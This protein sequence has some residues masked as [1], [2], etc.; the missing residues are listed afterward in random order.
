MR[1]RT[2]ALLA[3]WLPWSAF[4]GV[5]ASSEGTNSE[6]ERLAARNAVDGL[7]STAWAEG[8]DGNGAGAWLEVRLDGPTDVS[9]VSLWPGK[10]DRGNRGLREYGRP[11]TVTVTLAGAGD[12]VSQTVRVLDIAET[13]P[14]RVDVP[15]EGKARTVR[16]TID[17]AY[18]G[19]IRSDTYIT[20]VAVNFT[21]EPHKTVAAFQEWRGSDAGQRELTK[22]QEELAELKATIDEA[23]FGERDL[24]DRIKLAAS[25]GA[26][27][28]IKRAASRVTDGYRIRAVPPARAALNTLLELDDPN[29]IAAL[30]L[31]STR[32]TGKLQ[33]A[34][35]DR[36]ARYRALADLK[37]GNRRNVQPFGESGWCKGCLRSY[38]EPLAVGADGFGALWVADLANNRI[39]QFGFDGISRGD[40]GAGEPAITNNW[41]GRKRDWYASARTA[42]ADEG[43]FVLPVD[44]TVVPDKE[45]DTLF[46]LDA[47]G[48]VQHLTAG[49]KVLASWKLDVSLPLS[50]RVGGE[51]HIVVAKNKVV[52]AWSDECFVFDQEGEELGR[53]TFEDGPAGGM[54]AFKNGRVGVLF[55]GDLVQY[56]PDG[57]RYGSMLGDTV[58]DGYE[59]VAVATDEVGKLWVVTD[60]GYALKYKKPGKVDYQVKLMD[61]SFGVPRADVYQDL[62]FVSDG[63]KLQKFDALQMHQDAEAAE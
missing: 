59:Y 63:D 38:G 55:G 1:M 36:V 62:L 2:A 37:G 25:D 5:T 57:F 4:A 19:G 49:G 18:G 26:P 50:P 14:V 58:P 23:E 6:G 31:A 45:S 10:I 51:G 30:E 16:F 53:F 22:F 52:V 8:E 41:L 43:G 39:Q 27:H 9:S 42:T 61:W 33:A 35:T 15:I 34:I 7:L 13:G 20:E 29:A 21:G 24:F 47:G 44:L 40:I 28:D 3:A 56:S 48:R 11:H 60:H 12:E 17:E 32:T 46:V 54:V